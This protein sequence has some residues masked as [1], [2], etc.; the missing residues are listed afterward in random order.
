MPFLVLGRDG[1]P[2]T[3]PESG[4]ILH[5]ASREDAE[6]YRKAE[7]GWRVMEVPSPAPPA[8]MI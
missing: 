1:K 4:R 6:A 8:Q 5:F 2:M 7:N 3:H